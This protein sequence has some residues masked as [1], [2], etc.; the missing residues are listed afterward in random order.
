MSPH[1]IALLFNAN[2]VYDRQVLAGIGGYL[3]FTRVKWDLF[4]EEDFR[5]HALGIR[6]WRGDGI[7]ADFD[8]PV[9]AEAVSALSIPVVAIGGSYA[10]ES[11][12][13]NGIPYVATDNQK[14]VRM[15]YDH[16][17]D[18][19]LQRFA[20]FGRPL[21][22]GHLWAHEREMWFRRMTAADGLEGIVYHGSSVSAGGWGRAQEEMAEWV[23]AL[24]KPIGII[25]A[26]D[27]RARQLLQACVV[28]DV[29]IP[30]EVAVVGI[31]NDPIVQT[32]SSIRLT[33][34]IQG[35]EEMGRIAAQLLHQMLHG[36]DCSST[37]ILVPP[38]GIHVQGSS[39]HEHVRSPYVMRARHFIRQYACT[40]IK[41]EQVAGYVGVSRTLLEEHFKRELKKSVHQAILDHKLEVAM[42][43]LA[44][45]KASMAEVA[46]R[47]GFTSLQYMYAVFRREYDCTPKQFLAQRR[48]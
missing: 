47:S 30:D 25:A 41:S 6:Q 21:E 37:R 4:M 15:A 44:D 17:I 31:D 34:V 39:Q 26:T 18:H 19:G 42:Q 7:I 20:F 12:Y 46:V 8:D 29:P 13:P 16:L 23:R 32:L 36:G 24:P 40:G 45:P 33:S 14:L 10:D 9:V 1:R 48:V 22:P 35:A 38:S 2:K 5:S 27:A 3:T 11:Q 28:A 43:M